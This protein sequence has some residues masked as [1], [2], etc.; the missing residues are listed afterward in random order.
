[1]SKKTEL[2]NTITLPVNVD[3]QPFQDELVKL[4]TK[5]KAQET[6]IEKSFNKVGNLTILMIVE[7]SCYMITLFP[8]NPPNQKEKKAVNTILLSKDKLSKATWERISRLGNQDKI[9]ALTLKIKKDKGEA[10]ASSDVHA[11]MVQ[12]F[13]NA[14][15][16]K[17]GKPKLDKEGN[18]VPKEELPLNNLIK[19]FQK[20]R[21]EPMTDA[22]IKKAITNT[23]L[24]FQIFNKVSIQTALLSFSQLQEIEAIME[25]MEFTQE[26]THLVVPAGYRKDWADSVNKH[27]V[28]IAAYVNNN[29]K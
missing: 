22:E 19:E 5:V 29:N 9:R 15:K 23:D 11:A 17:N 18:P 28:N 14:V 13:G 12:E 24:T 7:Y 26:E 2:K 4:S 8:K 25:K 6:S 16:D 21:K 3:C 20:E 1:M 27:T 10:F